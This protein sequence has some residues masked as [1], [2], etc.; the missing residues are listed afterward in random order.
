ML[1]YCLSMFTAEYPIRYFCPR[2]ILTTSRVL[3]DKH[4]ETYVISNKGRRAEDVCHHLSALGCN[5]YYLQGGLDAWRNKNFPLAGMPKQ[6]RSFDR[7]IYA[8]SRL[9]LS[10]QKQ[11]SRPV[12]NFQNVRVQI[13]DC[14]PLRHYFDWIIGIVW[15]FEKIG[16]NV[17]LAF[18]RESNYFDNPI[19][20]IS[21]ECQT[22]DFLTIPFS[23]KQIL[24]CQVITGRL[25]N[26]YKHKVIARLSI[27][28]AV[29]KEADE[30][31]HKHLKG[32]WIAV[33]FRGTDLYHKTDY[34]EIDSYIDL[35]KK[36]IDK[37]RSI[38]A[39]SDQVQFIDRMH[40]EFPNKVFS[41]DIQRAS[42]R[43][44]LHRNI[45]KFEQRKEALIDLLILAKAK[46]VY[47]T[48]G[49]FPFIAQYFNPSL[50]IIS[51][52]SIIKQKIA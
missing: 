49:R 9:F 28:R 15:F 50:K 7:A 52:A 21:G 19:L 38:F 47:K 12:A 6:P 18:H 31:R 3:L 42:S 51:A 41:R 25:S 23:H 8:M 40:A 48:T 1:D 39:C 26:E 11:N 14:D 45:R 5:A 27:N 44:G 10:R 20:N 30:W 16:I 24:T 46:L 34:M 17:K 37:Q 29:Q 13:S 43:Q 36:V 22:K 2:L 4:R 33:H 32:D 35:L